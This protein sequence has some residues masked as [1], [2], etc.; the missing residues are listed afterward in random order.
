MIPS[1]YYKSVRREPSLTTYWRL[2]DEPT[3]VRA[4][5]WA[6]KYNI[7]GIYN[8]SSEVGPS[9]I[10]KDLSSVSREFN[11][12]ESSGVEIP[13]ILPLRIVGEITIEIWLTIKLSSQTSTILSKMN[14]AFTFANPYYLGIKSGEVIG[15][16][17]NGSSETTIAGKTLLLNVPYHIVFTS[18][19]TNRSMPSAPYSF[20]LYVN[21]ELITTKSTEQKMTDG[22]KAVYI[23]NKGNSTDEFKGYISEVSLYNKALSERTIKSHFDLGRQIL[24]EPARITTYDP[25]SFS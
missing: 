19:D 1:V 7:N 2:N 16:M 20:N 18:F 3:S 12:I 5:D 25:P 4:L 14:S 24:P 22:G 17:G 6:G 11:K 9:L 15:G 10:Y 13:D 23:G 8:G 21:G